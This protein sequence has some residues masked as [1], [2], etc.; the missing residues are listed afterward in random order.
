MSG[1]LLLRSN[2]ARVQI[3]SRLPDLNRSARESVFQSLLNLA[4]DM[5]EIERFITM[6]KAAL[7]RRSREKT[8][9]E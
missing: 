2:A 7:E 1:K 8:H 3:D 6:S 4:D 9:L 5:L